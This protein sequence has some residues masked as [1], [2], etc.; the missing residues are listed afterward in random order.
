[1]HFVDNLL[2]QIEE[3]NGLDKRVG[4]ELQIETATGLKNIHEIAARVRPRG[5]ADL[6]PGRHERV[7]RAAHGDGRAADARATPATTGTTC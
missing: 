4:L 6:R 1:M 7:A 2:R 5:D 3:T